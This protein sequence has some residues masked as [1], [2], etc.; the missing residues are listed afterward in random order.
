MRDSTTSVLLRS[1]QDKIGQFKP[2]G[3]S[4]IKDT[5]ME[6]RIDTKF[7]LTSRGLLSSLEFFRDSYRILNINSVRLHR[8]QTLYF[9]T[10]R[11]DLYLRHHSGARNSYKVRSRQYLDSYRSFLEVKKKINPS[12]SLKIRTETSGMV[13]KISPDD[14]GHFVEANS[15]IMSRY[16]API[17]WNYFN[18]ITLL[19]KTKPERLTLDMSLRYSGAGSR[20]LIPNLCV[21]ELK[22]ESIDRSSVAYRYMRSIGARPT[23]FSKYGIG[24]SMLYPTVKHNRIRPKLR[25]IEKITGGSG[26]VS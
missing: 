6:N 22:Q 19:H 12:R 25:M 9:D 21:A 15:S 14:T 17:L 1:L 4:E 20:V 5:A 23:G 7:L 18:R 11:F 8:Y 10:K 13:T 3:L 16:L 2:V 24:V 26:L